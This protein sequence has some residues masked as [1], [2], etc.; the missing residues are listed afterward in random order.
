M[1]KLL[2]ILED[3]RPDLEFAQETQ[4]VDGGIIDSFDIFSIYERIND[5]FGISID[6][7]DIVPENFNSVEAMMKL[8]ERYL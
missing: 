3:V 1:D 7:E 6:V 2:E 4:L 8:V 5:A